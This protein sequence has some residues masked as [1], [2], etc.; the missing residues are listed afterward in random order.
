MYS[1]NRCCTSDSLSGKHHRVLS[2]QNKTI[3]LERDKMKR[4]NV[5]K[6]WIFIYFSGFKY[7]LGVVN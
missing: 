3:N 4:R 7:F 1:M 5:G 2:L 6:V